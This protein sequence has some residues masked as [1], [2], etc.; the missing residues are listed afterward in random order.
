MAS[1]FDDTQMTTAPPEKENGNGNGNGSLS[2]STL[3][4]YGMHGHA[5]DIETSN[6]N[7]AIEPK[8]EA[9]HEDQVEDIDQ[10]AFRT[11][12]PQQPVTEKRKPYVPTSRDHLTDFGVA[13]ATIAASKEH[14]NG[15][16]QDGYAR[17]HQHQTVSPLP[18]VLK[19]P[20]G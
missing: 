17:T 8:V 6:A 18:F 4:L 2:L 3:K 16:T 14:P 5:T 15:T 20:R 7:S 1:P 10:L 11:A 9:K 12:I 13:R 19:I